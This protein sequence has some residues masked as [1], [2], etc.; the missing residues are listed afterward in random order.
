[1]AWSVIM[2]L[3]LTEIDYLGFVASPP[4]DPKFKS[5][6]RARLNGRA[7]HG[8]GQQS[9]GQNSTQHASRYRAQ[10]FRG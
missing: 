8:G 3:A 5:A 2:V 1:M 9:N 6:V 7:P 4:I 10:L